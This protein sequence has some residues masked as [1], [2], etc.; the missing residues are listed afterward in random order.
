MENPEPSK[1]YGVKKG[2]DHIREI[3]SREEE[4]LIIGKTY[5]VA[6]PT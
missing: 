6:H 3:L 4:N 1:N 2:S 5:L